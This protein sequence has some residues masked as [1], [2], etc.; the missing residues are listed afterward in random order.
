MG[1]LGPAAYAF[2][3]GAAGAGTFVGMASVVDNVVGPKSGTL[4]C[5]APEGSAAMA[6]FT[7]L[8]AD[9]DAALAPGGA[10]DDLWSAIAVTTVSKPAVPP[11]ATIPFLPSLRPLLCTA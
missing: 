2:G 1:A 4:A 7:V 8:V 9:S 3:G 10:D 6:P 11:K 5:T